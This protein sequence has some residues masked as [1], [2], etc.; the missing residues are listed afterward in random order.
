[1]K[2]VE[3]FT[4]CPDRDFQRRA[5]GKEFVL[6]HAHTQAR[7]GVF[8]R[9]VLEDGRQAACVD[10]KISCRKN[11][12]LCRFSLALFRGR[13]GSTFLGDAGRCGKKFDRRIVRRALSRQDAGDRLKPLRRPKIRDQQGAL[14]GTKNLQ[15]LVPYLKTTIYRQTRYPF[16][17]QQHKSLEGRR[18]IREKTQT[19]VRAKT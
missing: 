1:M 4:A 9:S 12:F 5:C 14:E 2:G 17:V 18:E 13:R 3:L 16:P 8:T 11:D 7:T 6:P 15:R 19:T 10:R